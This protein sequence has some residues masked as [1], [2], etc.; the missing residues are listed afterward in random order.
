MSAGSHPTRAMRFLSLSEM[1]SLVSRECSWQTSLGR[2]KPVMVASTCSNR[3]DIVTGTGKYGSRNV[4]SLLHKVEYQ[5]LVTK[6][7]P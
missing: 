5:V 3:M 6:I 7:S 4:V 2:Q 1:C